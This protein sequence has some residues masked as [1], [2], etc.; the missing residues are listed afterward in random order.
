MI[1]LSRPSKMPCPSW[2]LE[3]IETCPASI[4]SDGDLVDACKGCYAVG[5]N[6]RFPNVR[7]VRIHNKQDWKRDEWVSDMVVALQNYRYF[8]W[9]DSGDV[10]HKKLAYKI[11]EVCKQTEWCNHWIPTRMHKFAKFKQVL[12]ELNELPNVVVRYSSDSVTGKTIEGKYTS[13][14]IPFL[15]IKTKATICMAFEREGKCGTCRAC[16]SKDEPLIAYVAH[17]RAMKSLLMNKGVA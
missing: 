6:Y 5:G 1:K 15:K 7:N 17:G 8:R 4:G 13:T 14:I 9:F 2:S 16:W 12:N 3:A 10:Y 11:L